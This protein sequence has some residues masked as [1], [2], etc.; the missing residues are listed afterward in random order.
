MLIKVDDF[1]YIINNDKTCCCYGVADRRF[2][3]KYEEI[4]IPREIIY[5]GNIYRVTKIDGGGF[6][7]CKSKKII[8]PDT[9]ETIGYYSFSE[10]KYL[11]SIY[12]PRSVK[13]IEIFCFSY[14][15]RLRD[16][17][18]E[19][20]PELIN[21]GRGCFMESKFID[22]LIS[23]KTKIGYLGKNLVAVDSTVENLYIEP[24]TIL[25]YF[26][27]K[28]NYSLKTIQI[29]KSLKLLYLPSLT[30]INDIYF[31]TIDDFINCHIDGDEVINLFIGGDLIKTLELPN[32]IKH[33]NVTKLKLIRN[34]TDIRLNLN[35]EEIS[36]FIPAKKENRR[37]DNLYFPRGL[38]SISSYY[39]FHNARFN[40]IG[41][42]F[43]TLQRLHIPF[44]VFY[45]K[46]INIYFDDLV[47]INNKKWSL[48]LLKDINYI[49]LVII[50]K[51]TSDDLINIL[52]LLVRAI[53]DNI[54]WKHKIILLDSDFLKI[55]DQLPETYY[56]LLKNNWI[57]FKVSEVDYPKFQSHAIWGEF[58][59]NITIYY[60]CNKYIIDQET[61]ICKLD[62][63]L[64]EKQENSYTGII[65]LPKETIINGE[66]YKV[67]SVSD[68][69]LSSC[70][71]LENIV[72]QENQEINE[73]LALF[74]SP[75]KIIRV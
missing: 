53:K 62:V 25:A 31:D 75:T 24:G 46:S 4:T 44:H 11:E 19:G 68:F 48:G 51:T 61:K 39:C 63:W 17:I 20:D 1:R 49:S 38:K 52:N 36:G 69:A 34:I 54:L 26:S 58:I 35:L 66:I 2:R 40:S 32:N 23:T 60:D 3:F 28:I 15:Y 14:C 71:Y 42:N 12:I 41:I 45:A 18:F 10:C 67:T 33:F 64:D 9:L 5:E 13:N 29:P 56:T 16:V 22:N 73:N 65:K 27:D 21:I 37:F 70:P 72:L 6:I 74:N 50:C 55:K 57:N 43:S 30:T 59:K 8:L 47:E 7:R